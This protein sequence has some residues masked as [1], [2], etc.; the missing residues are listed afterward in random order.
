ECAGLLY[1]CQSVDG[2]QMVGAIEADAV[3]TRRLTLRYRSVIADH[4]QLLARTGV[5]VTGHEFHRTAV[6]PSH[7][8]AA[9]WFVDGEPTGFSTDP[10]G[11]GRQTVH[12]SYLHLHWAGYPD[13]AQRFANAVHDHAK[14]MRP[15]S[16]EPVEA[17]QLAP[18]PAAVHDLQHHGDRDFAEGLVDLAVNVRLSAPP[19]WLSAIINDTI[20]DLAAYPNTDAASKAIAEA[21][22]VTVDQ[23]LPTA[24][25]AEAF[26]LLARAFRP[27]RPLIIHPQFTEPE[28][29]LIA[30]G[31]RPE[32]LILSPANNFQLRADQLPRQADLIIIGNPTNPTSVLHPAALLNSLRR[33]GRVIVVDEA[34]MDAVPGEPE[35][36][37]R[38]DLTGLL[39]LRS[40]TKT[41]G[42][43]GLRAGYVI[44]EPKLITALREQQP[45]WSVSTPALAAITA[46]LTPDARSLAVAAADEIA[47]RRAYLVGQLASVG[48]Q[49]AYPP[50]AP[51]VLVDTGGVRR[52][53]E[54]G[55]IRLAL[56]DHGFAVR[57]GETFPGLGPDWIRIAVR[58]PETTDQLVAALRRL[59]RL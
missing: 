58:E 56:R 31:H 57:R 45:P 25:G 55:W 17:H 29:A 16:A 12:A 23:V 34:F 6:E 10:G 24:G 30:A 1:L 53:R 40:L 26:T 47:I 5:P 33:P 37:I 51:F 59:V 35:T 44:G 4:D 48:L 49:V 7:G 9:A 19:D 39:V 11:I 43:A 52:D 32:R 13:L 54:P 14:T 36:M 8:A 42:L 3:M 28:A 27:D 2:L 18:H 38:D 50:Q 15:M 46:C 22:A 20:Q 41:W 21:H